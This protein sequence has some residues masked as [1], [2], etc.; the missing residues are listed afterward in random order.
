MLKKHSVTSN[1][2]IILSQQ[3]MLKEFWINRKC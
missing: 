3:N 1:A 2:R